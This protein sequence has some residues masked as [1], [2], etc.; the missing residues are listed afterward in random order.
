MR[1]TLWSKS[2]VHVHFSD[3]DWHSNTN[4]IVHSSDV[5]YFYHNRRFHSVFIEKSDKSTNR[6]R[7]NC[8]Y[9]VSESASKSDRLLQT[10]PVRCVVIQFCWMAVLVATVQTC[11]FPSVQI[12]FLKTQAKRTLW[13]CC[14]IVPALLPTGDNTIRQDRQCTFNVIPKR[15]CVTIVVHILSVCVCSLS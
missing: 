14:R 12:F 11:R 3:S 15:F 9:F 1:S 10:H 13:M 8:D 4:R 6:I 2:G 7:A 5:C